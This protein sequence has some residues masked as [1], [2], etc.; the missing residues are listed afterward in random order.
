MFEESVLETA[1]KFS[2]YT[3][4]TSIIENLG[5]L[6]FRRK[7]LPLATQFSTV[8]AILAGDFD[9]D[10]KVD[11]LLAG[12]FFPVN[13]QMGRY[14]ASF[15]SFLK[16]NGKGDFRTV[17][18]THS[19]FS[20]RGETKALRK[21]T[22]GNTVYYLAVRNNDVIEAFKSREYPVALSTAGVK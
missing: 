14:D 20:V 12:N 2:A 18:G 19:G 4:E 8:N 1:L 16:G 10:Q 13:I 7:A 3:F 15:G 21:I 22:I 6:K 11:L 9:H 5:G 17:P